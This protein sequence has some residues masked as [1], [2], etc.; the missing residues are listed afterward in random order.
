MTDIP[1]II[2]LN[3]DERICDEEGNPY[4]IETRGDRRCMYFKASDIETIV[5]IK[6]ITKVLQKD[7]FVCD[8]DYV[9]FNIDGPT[10]F[11]TYAGL[12]QLLFTRRHPIADKFR[13][14][15]TV[16]KYG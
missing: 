5:K 4:D 11:L 16:Q 15:A 7:I 12:T 2:K 13:R 6:N 14:W 9:T 1:D 10:L 3:D 8:R